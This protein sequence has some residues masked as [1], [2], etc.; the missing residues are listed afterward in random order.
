MNHPVLADPRVDQPLGQLA[1][2]RP[3]ATAVLRRLGL[4]FCCGGQ[5]LL[6][7]ACR[8]RGLDPAGVLRELDAADPADAVDVPLEPAALVDHILARYHEAHRAQLPEL[9]ALA[10]RVEAVHAGHPQVPAGLADLLGVMHDE[11]LDHMA[12]E[13]QILFPLL[14]AGGHPMVR[15]PIAVMRH[16]HTAH[17]AQL[18][19]LAT[20]THDHTPPAD[21]CASWQALYAG[22]RRFSDDLMQ[23]IHLENNLLFPAFEGGAGAGT[24]RR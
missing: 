11:M 5:A 9:I 6:G 24:A 19:R 7:D 15:H 14:K 17:G 21:A 18:E 1:V 22:T 16:E 13:E 4:D 8:A 2:E 12:K 3:G 20:L 10:R 23:H